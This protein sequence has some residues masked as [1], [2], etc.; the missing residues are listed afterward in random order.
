M[1]KTEVNKFLQSTSVP[2]RGTCSMDWGTY[3]MG[4]GT[5][6][7][8]WGT[9]QESSDLYTQHGLKWMTSLH[10]E[11]INLFFN[12]RKNYVFMIAKLIS[13]TY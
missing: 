6:S 13:L 12:W 4:W 9:S 3:S 5:F 10:V 8:G 1:H 2:K 11:P 7:M